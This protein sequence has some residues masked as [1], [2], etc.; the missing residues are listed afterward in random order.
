MG[1]IVKLS[2]FLH[3][4]ATDKCSVLEGCG[5][6]VGSCKLGLTVSRYLVRLMSTLLRKADNEIQ[7]VLLSMPPKLVIARVA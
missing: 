3:S 1:M 5:S 6:T 7:S 4:V 2:V